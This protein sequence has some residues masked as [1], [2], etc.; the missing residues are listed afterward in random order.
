MLNVVLKLNKLYWYIIIAKSNVVKLFYAYL[1]IK[2][3]I[4]QQ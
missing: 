3:P 2:F 4:A 1:A